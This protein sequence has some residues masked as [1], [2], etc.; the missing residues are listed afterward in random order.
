MGEVHQYS[1]Q[2]HGDLQSVSTELPWAVTHFFS[3]EV[4]GL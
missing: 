2:T 1:H 3:L 4:S